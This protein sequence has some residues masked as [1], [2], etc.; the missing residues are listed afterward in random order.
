MSSINLTVRS[1]CS[2]DE[3]LII[4]DFKLLSSFWSKKTATS[5]LSGSQKHPLTAPEEKNAL[6]AMYLK[7]MTCLASG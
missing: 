7:A 4:N 3:L 2:L 6:R 1:L 5:V